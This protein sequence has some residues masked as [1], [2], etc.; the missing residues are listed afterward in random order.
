VVLRLENITSQT[1]APAYDVYLNVPSGDDP[2]THPELH[3]GRAG[4]F[5]IA[6]ASTAG[7]HG[8]SGLNLSFDI[9]S[10]YAQLSAAAG[11][12]A[13]ALRVSFVPVTGKASTAR[14]HVG[15]VSLYFA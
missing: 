5:G 4:L 14:V 3:A 7:P 1:T 13:D 6:Q 15:R 10:L 8:G 11:F 9:T 12:R 2:A